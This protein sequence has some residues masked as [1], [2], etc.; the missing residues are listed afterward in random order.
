M[1]CSALGD[2]SGGSVGV[3]FDTWHGEG[4]WDPVIAQYPGVISPGQY[5]LGNTVM[6]IGAGG[7]GWPD[8]QLGWCEDPADPWANYGEVVREWPAG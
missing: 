6:S 3:K 8:V 2:G 4:A 5:T 7:G 1:N